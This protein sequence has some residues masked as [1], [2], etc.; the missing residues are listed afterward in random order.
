[1]GVSKEI[2]EQVLRINPQDR[3]SCHKIKYILDKHAIFNMNNP[4]K[5]NYSTV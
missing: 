3:I 2:M 1:M 5:A 4:K